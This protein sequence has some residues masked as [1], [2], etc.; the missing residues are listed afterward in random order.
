MQVEF[1]RM[2][3]DRRFVL[4]AA[5]ILI[6]PQ[7]DIGWVI[8][9][10]FLAG[11]DEPKFI[12]HPAMGSFLAGSSIGHYGQMILVWLLPVILLGLVADRAVSDSR[13]NYMVAQMIRKTKARY[14]IDKL[15]FVAVVSMAVTVISLLLNFLIAFIFLHGGISFQG[16]EE[17]VK[18]NSSQL[19]YQLAHPYST[20]LIITSVYILIV[21]I[22]AMVCY[23][24]SIIFSS[25]YWVYPIAFLVWIFQ[26]MMR[27]SLAFL[28][29]PFME[30]GLAYQ[31]PAMLTF[32][33]IAIIIIGGGYY[34]KVRT[35][36]IS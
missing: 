27:N 7:L 3:H 4:F 36:A 22:Y 23:M 30:Y 25:Y 29:Q 17:S 32:G 21:G 34:W 14:L 9:N 2:L 31:I 26:I 35:D 16:N 6:V 18:F 13:Q 5:V 33:L 10:Q 15:T 12:L 24:L 19:N 1:R 8:H 28:M 20:L 11:M